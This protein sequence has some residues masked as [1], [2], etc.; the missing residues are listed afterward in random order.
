M[1]SKSNKHP[2]WF[3]RFSGTAATSGLLC[4]FLFSSPQTASADPSVSDTQK[5][6]AVQQKGQTVSGVVTDAKGNPLIG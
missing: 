2:L 6:Q 1:K 3:K 4:L 5:A